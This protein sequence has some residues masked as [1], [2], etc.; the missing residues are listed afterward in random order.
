MILTNEENSSFRIFL[1]IFLAMTARKKSDYV[2]VND[3]ETVVFLTFSF[4]K[5][6]KVLRIQ[7][8]STTD[9]H[10]QYL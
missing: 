5:L 10:F 6:Q 2:V 4:T 3:L 8:S 9:K 1:N 7:T